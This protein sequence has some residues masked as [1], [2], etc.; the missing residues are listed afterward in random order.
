[1]INANLT[2]TDGLKEAWTAASRDGNVRALAIDIDVD[3]ETINLTDTIAPAG[4]AEADFNALA[5]RLGDTEPAMFLVCLD[6]ETSTPGTQWCL[7]SYV[8]DD[9]HIKK[10]ML[11]ASGVTD[12]RAALSIGVTDD[13]HTS[14]KGEFTWS[15]LQDARRVAA[16][17]DALTAAEKEAAK[18]M[19]QSN[20][21]RGAGAGAGAGS[22]GG[23]GDG[24]GGL[25]FKLAQGATD[26][27]KRAAA[28]EVNFVE[29]VFADD[30]FI[31]AGRSE[32][33]SG[34]AAGMS[35]LVNTE[36]PRFLVVNASDG[37]D[38]EFSESPR[39]GVRCASD[40][41]CALLFRCSAHAPP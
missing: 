9:S 37:K 18:E 40:D 32:K 20:V 25:P 26:A 14:V 21:E 16:P 1:M 34:G 31:D 33:V 11:Y 29:L 15:E 39:A 41:T 38:D 24:A 36:E 13:F 27:L 5:E 3:E 12:L 19:R 8:P 4:D 10:R 7:A 17:D 2:V 22:G 28:G 23:G 30:E 35:S 6:T